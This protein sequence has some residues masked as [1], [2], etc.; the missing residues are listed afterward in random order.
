M[1]R[2][3]NLNNI[4]SRVLA[5]IAFTGIVVPGLCWLLQILG[6]DWPALGVLM[7]AGLWMGGALLVLFIALVLIEQIQDHLL[8]RAYQRGLSR[9][10]QGK[11]G[12]SECPYCGNR[13]LKDFETCCPICGKELN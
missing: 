1:H 13:A 8:Y 9:R 12:R 3:L 7:R 11:E 10:L 6:L 4:S 5:V 2:I